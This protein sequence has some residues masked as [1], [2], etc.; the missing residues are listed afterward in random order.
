MIGILAALYQRQATGIG[1]RIEVA[2]Q[3]AVIN[4][5]RIAYAAQ[6]AINAP[7]PRTGNQTFLAGTS[8]SEV[9]PCKGGGA[10]DYCY[11]YT[12]RAGNH[13]WERLLT[14]IGREDLLAAE[15]FTTPKARQENYKTVD[16]IIAEWTINHDKR[17]VMKLF[18]EAGI[19]ASAVFKRWNLRSIPTCASAARLFR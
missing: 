16:A 5:G 13:H 4:F 2:M 15:R 18:G 8:P 6:A 3:D 10:N 7:A 9:Y 1:Q 11:V 17:H 19:P 12:T 14:V